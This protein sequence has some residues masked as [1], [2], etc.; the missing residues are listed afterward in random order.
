MQAPPSPHEHP[1][2][3]KTFLRLLKV[4]DEK[5]AQQSCCLDEATLY[6]LEQATGDFY[7]AGKFFRCCA[8]TLARNS[9]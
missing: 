9:K 6:H 4:Y 5:V 3:Y 1:N 8:L 2:P 7:D